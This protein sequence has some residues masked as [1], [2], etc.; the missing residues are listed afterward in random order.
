MV[1]FSSTIIESHFNVKRLEW[2][3][4]G[5]L[6]S[7]LYHSVLLKQT[8]MKGYVIKES[9]LRTHMHW[10]TLHALLSSSC[11]DSIERNTPKNF[12]RGSYG[13]LS[14]PQTWANWQS[15]VS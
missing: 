9:S 5:S 14:L 8:Q 15:N 2:K 6:E 12:S 1:A 3:L 13:F 10:S 4:K 11:Q 7:R